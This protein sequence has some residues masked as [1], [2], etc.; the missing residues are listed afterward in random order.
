LLVSDAIN[1]TAVGR[2]VIPSFITTSFILFF[3]IDI[4]ACNYTYD[5]VFVMMNCL[6][7]CLMTLSVPKIVELKAELD[8]ASVEVAVL[9]FNPVAH[10]FLISLVYVYCYVNQSLLWL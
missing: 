1:I 10:T 6:V 7:F 3:L 2:T 9:N 4:F 5:D 8:C